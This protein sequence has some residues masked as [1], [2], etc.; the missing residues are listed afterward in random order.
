MVVRVSVDLGALY[1]RI[2][3]LF[4]VEGEGFK[5]IV[6]DCIFRKGRKVSCNLT[7]LV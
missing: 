5:L 4:Q 1:V 2:T 7:S 6:L 3:P